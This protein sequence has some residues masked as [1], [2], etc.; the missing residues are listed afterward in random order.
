MKYAII[1]SGGKQYK[2]VEGEMIEVDRL[3]AASGGQIDLDPVLLMVEGDQIAVGTPTVAGIQV[4]ATVLDHFRGPKVV[5]FKY[6]PKKRYRV[7]GGHR[8][9]HTRLMIDWV[10]KPGEF[11]KAAKVEQ[12]AGAKVERPMKVGKAPAKAAPA[13]AVVVK[14]SVKPS[15]RKKVAPTAKAAAKPKKAPETTKTVKPSAASKPKKT[16]KK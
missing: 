16:A 9:Q 12:S 4:K 2:V 11:K 13:K 10:G 5:I 1:E 6:R 14:K 3:P 15:E 7:K 8:Q